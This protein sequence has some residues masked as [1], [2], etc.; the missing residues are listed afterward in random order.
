MERG[1]LTSLA[2]F[3]ASFSIG[4]AVPPYPTTADIPRSSDFDFLAGTW[5]LKITSSLPGIPPTMRGRWTAAHA[6]D[7]LVLEDEYRIFD[8]GSSTVYLGKTY[9]VW[10]HESKAWKI[11][12]LDLMKG[13]WYEARGWRDG[14][15]M[16]V[17][18]KGVA[19]SPTA[20]LR[21]QYLDITP[22]RFQW[23]SERS[24]D[25]GSTWKPYGLS[26]EATRSCAEAAATAESAERRLATAKIE[27]MDA[28]YRADLVKL[29]QLRESLLPLKQHSDLGF[30]A[31]YWAG[32][33]SWRIALNGASLGM[34]SSDIK[35]HLDSAAADFAD[36]TRSRADF[37]DGY[38]AAA[39]VNGWLISFARPD[40]TAMREQIALAVGQLERA[41]KLEPE[42]P[43]VLWVRG[44]DFLFR[45]MEHGGDPAKAVE[46]Y[47]R[48][49]EV[50]PDRLQGRLLPDWGRAESLM[51]LAYA[52]L[53]HLR[54]LPAAEREARGALRLQPEWAYVRDILLPQIEAA[55]SQASR[56]AGRAPTA[57]GDGP[58]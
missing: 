7:G 32:F 56:A 30:L 19:A 21:F 5:D 53:N 49:A 45:P 22:D 34:S 48:A 18:Q 14:A 33:A 8:D 20:L 36:S 24:D 2:L 50:S 41:T 17:E 54:D 23:R 11:R 28:D 51:A 16:R 25:G 4:A 10:N 31:H 13:E 1:V 9:R 38:A 26:I 39:S 46:L 57:G 29:A 52:H 43:R 35:A 40:P 27:L 15:T 58:R 44:G 6:A 37:A 12:Y 47:R 42:N 55:S 3:F